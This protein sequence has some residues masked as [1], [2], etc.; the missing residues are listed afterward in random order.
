[1]K[2][3]LT[4]RLLVCKTAWATDQN[5]TQ[6]DIKQLQNLIGVQEI[7]KPI[8]KYHHWSEKES[9]K[10]LNLLSKY[11]EN[12]IIK[13]KELAMEMPWRTIKQIIDHYQYLIRTDVIKRNPHK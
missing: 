8:R 1:M 4:G 12:E 9:N 13:W 11:E 5:W 6:N 2:K 7:Q 3:F 10:L